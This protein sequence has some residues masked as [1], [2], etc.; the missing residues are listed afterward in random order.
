[1]RMEILSGIAADESVGE[2]PWLRA[3]R[4]LLRRRAAMIGVAV[5]LLFIVAAAAAPL[6]APYDPLATNWAAVRKAPSASHLFGTD[7]IGRDVLARI[8]WGSRASLLAGLVSV[9]LALA[10]GVPVGLISGYVGGVGLLALV[11]SLSAQITRLQAGHPLSHDVV[12]WPLILLALGAC[13][14]IAGSLRRTLGGRP[15]D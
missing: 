13:G 3:V 5:A 1:M 8:I 14:L 9:M 12:G 7:E 11:I 10:I 15:G 4:R 2:P 6:L